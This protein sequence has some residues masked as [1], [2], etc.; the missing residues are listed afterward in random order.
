MK[1]ILLLNPEIAKYYWLEFS[2]Q[3]WITMPAILFLLSTLIYIMSENK[4]EAMIAIHYASFYGF[5]FIGVIWGIKN[6][7]DGILDE[8]NEKTW[9][10]QRRSPVGPWKLA[11]GKLFGP[12]IYNWYGALICWGI[13]MVSASYTNQPIQALKTGWTLIPSTIG[14]HGLMILIALLLVRKNQGLIKIKSNRTFL[15]GILFLI[16]FSGLLSYFNLFRQST[17]DI[18]WF[19][20]KSSFPNILL[21]SCIIYCLW[22][23]YG[24]FRSM[25]TALQYENGP[26]IWLAFLAFHFLFQYGF[27]LP[28]NTLVDLQAFTITSVLLFLECIFLIYALALSE[29]IDVVA[30]KQHLKEFSKKEYASLFRN[31]PLWI[32][33]IPPAK[34]VGLFALAGILFSSDQ[35]AIADL[36]KILH[37]QDLS[38][39]AG[40]YLAVL[41]FMMRD[42]MVFML[43]HLSGKPQRADA[44]FIIYLL[45]S[46]LIIPFLLTGLDMPYLF[47]PYSTHGQVL[48]I[49]MPM[50]EALV[51]LY[52]LKNK[53]TFI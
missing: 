37:I 20:V 14:L 47:F 34:I 19:G 2:P 13:Y 51:A 17:A 9:D 50:L 25:R 12:T 30:Y 46:Y 22:I 15:Y 26:S 7:S 6:A 36:L 1:K 35:T 45:L 11:L 32:L 23:I 39:A 21:F 31:L 48:L 8:F 10:W 43:F 24:I 53:W 40:T 3:R 27:F 18:L 44:S 49:I 52:L 33:T 29:N 41:F 4:E 28:E 38:F 5:I 42:L 16:L